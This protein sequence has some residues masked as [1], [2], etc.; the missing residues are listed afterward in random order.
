MAIGKNVKGEKLISEDIG[1]NKPQ[2]EKLPSTGKAA[3][4]INLDI[5]VMTTVFNKACLI[6]MTDKKGFITYVNDKFCEAAK[7]T[8]E[9]LIGKNHNIVR[10]QDMPKSLFKEVWATIG[11][12]EIF[13]GL[14]KNKAKDGTPY[15]VDAYICPVLGADGKPE[16]YIGIRYDIT[17]Q[18]LA[19]EESAQKEKRFSDTLEQAN[20]AVVIINSDKEILFF[21]KT[22]EKIFGYRPDEVMGQNVKMI[23]PPEHQGPH[24]EYVNRNMRTGENK[25]VGIGRELEMVRKGGERF[26]GHLS[27]SKSDLNGAI[28][29]TAF[30]KD[31]SVQKN[32]EVENKKTMERMNG[33]LDQAVDA[34]ITIDKDKNINFFNKR[35]E[36]L[37]GY[38]REEVLGKNVKTIVP[39]AHQAPH[40]GYIDA[41][42]KTGINKVVGLGRDLEMVRKDG[43]TFWG[44]LGLSKVVMGDEIIFTAFIKD[45]TIQKHN[46][47]ANEQITNAVSK[48]AA[49]DFDFKFDFTGLQMDEKTKEVANTIESLR[50]NLNQILNEVNVV[51]KEAGEEGNLNSRLNVEETKGAWKSL[52]DSLNIL[53]NSISEPILEFNSIINKMAEGDLTKRFKMDAKGSIKEM[54]DSLNSA[55]GNL[56]SLLINIEKSSNVV[57][58]SAGNSLSMTE[59]M[60]KNTRE[61]A[62]AIAQIAKGAQDQAQRTDESAKLVNEV[63]ESSNEMETKADFINKTAENGQKS[64]ENGMKIMKVLVQNMTG[65][66]DSANLTA[67]SIGVLTQ[68]AEEIGRTLNVITDIAAQTN[69]L[70]LNAAI[71]AARAGDAG[72]G[73]AVVAEEIRKLAEDSRKSAIEIEKI[74]GDVQKD[75]QSASKAIETMEGSVK[76]G[77]NAT[78][79]AEKIFKDIA[80]SSEETFNISQEI[81]QVTS[82]QKNSIDAVA[83]NIEQIVVVAEETAAG[84]QQVASSSQELNSSMEEIGSVSAKLSEIA[85]ELQAGVNQFT[86]NK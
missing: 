22:A 5:D 24:D 25:V 39:V 56:N 68:R 67:K 32:L 2:K 72:R 30:I 65:I 7:Y 31:I 74:V 50:D 34:V 71:E 14:I 18:I 48:I 75:T 76:E 35:A 19:N 84:A 47:L 79:D 62:A 60:K 63:L 44:N 66:S 11:K 33:T 81:R 77:N 27:L 28:T 38:K 78:I 23:V 10:H 86:L 70:A 58:D 46:E 26:W 40:D 29:Y 16:R 17:E 9:E 64:S 49:G 57:A 52:I 20:D 54:A 53:L 3:N 15:W 43:S 80:S 21:N 4:N 8:R 12:G 85:S 82:E 42:I 69:L 73:F 61:V 55:M 1:D 59:G 36:E 51:V 41:N 37:F 83:K 6:S 13:N 45:I